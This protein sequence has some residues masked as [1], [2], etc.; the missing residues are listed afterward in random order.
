MG[1]DKYDLSLYSEGKWQDL[2]GISCIQSEQRD[3]VEGWYNV[4]ICQWCPGDIIKPKENEKKWN[5]RCADRFVG[6][7]LGVTSRETHNNTKGKHHSH[8]RISHNGRRPTRSIA[9]AALVDII[10][11]KWVRL[12]YCPKNWTLIL[13]IPNLK[14]NIELRLLLC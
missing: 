14:P 6:L 11:G 1:C 13:T 8:C 7:I 12:L 4:Q 5:N 9:N 10:T 3:A 2:D